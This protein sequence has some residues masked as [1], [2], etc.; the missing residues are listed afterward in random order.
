M[1]GGPGSSSGLLSDEDFSATVTK[2]VAFFKERGIREITLRE[3]AT[4]PGVAVGYVVHVD[5]KARIVLTRT[6]PPLTFFIGMSDDYIVKNVESPTHPL[7]SEERGQIKEKSKKTMHVRL[8]DLAALV[9][10]V[11]EYCE[12]LVGLWKAPSE[13]PPTS[14]R[15]SRRLPSNLPSLPQSITPAGDKPVSLPPIRE[16][17]RPG[18]AGTEPSPPLD[19]IASRNRELTNLL[20][21]IEKVIDTIETDRIDEATLSLIRGWFN[22]LKR[23][24][25]GP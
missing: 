9:N 24:L 7:T 8:D 18:D 5:C 20:M 13:P 23:Q 21:R 14:R 22:T 19:Y 6:P 10:S 1:E 3:H 4:V 17:G 15:P 2:I 16:T 25:N 12:K 11:K